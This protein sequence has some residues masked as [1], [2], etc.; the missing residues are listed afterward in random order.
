MNKKSFI[1]LIAVLLLVISILTEM[2]IVEIA[3][4]NPFFMFNRIEP[5]SGTIP[6]IITILSPQNNTSYSSNRI[7]VSFNVSNQLDTHEAIYEIQYAWDN[8]KNVN[9]F[10]IWKGGSASSSSA[11]P[12]FNTTFTSPSL[13]AGNHSLTVREY[14]VYYAGV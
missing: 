9:A 2:S 11:I 14:S 4:A 6:P 3:S 5:I 7:A 1:V 10:T 12:E 13:S 8:G